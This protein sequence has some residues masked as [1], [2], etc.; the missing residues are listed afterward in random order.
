MAVVGII[1]TLV[2]LLLPSLTR[3]RSVARTT[4]CAS[5]LH[6]LSIAFVEYVTIYGK[7]PPNVS[8]PSPG[9]Y[10]YDDDRIGR[11]LPASRPPVPAGKP[12]GNIYVCPEDVGPA[13]LSY[14]MNEWASSAADSSVTSAL[15]VTGTFWSPKTSPSCKLILI[16]ESYSGNGSQSIGWY[17]A[18]TIGFA[19][20][21]A[22][23]RFGGNGGIAPPVSA[24]RW[25]YVNSELNFMRHRSSG[26]GGVSTQPK[27]RLNIAYADGHVAARSDADLVTAAGV[28]TGDSDWSPMDWGGR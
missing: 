24:Q 3:V 5:N 8:S 14:S 13:Y 20:S 25:G 28:S 18:P 17:S 9:Q 23:A 22:A 10:W 11:F 4:Q 2:G 27:G 12:G 7:F 19:G 26:S 15:P 21:S 6:Q 16:A 1:A